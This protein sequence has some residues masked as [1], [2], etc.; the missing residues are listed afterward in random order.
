MLN[1]NFLIAITNIALIFFI[2][3]I[4][5]YATI[6]P[7]SFYSFSY[8][9]RFPVSVF[10]LII[11]SIILFFALIFIKR[12]NPDKNIFRLIL[13]SILSIII[14]TFS[15]FIALSFSGVVLE[16][17][18]ENNILDE[19]WS[20]FF[21]ILFISYLS[22]LAISILLF[23]LSIPK[24][25]F[26]DKTYQSAFRWFIVLVPL[27]VFTFVIFFIF[28]VSA[29]AQSQENAPTFDEN[30]CPLL[31]WQNELALIGTG[32]ILSLCL[33]LIFRFI[34]TKIANKI[35]Q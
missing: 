33:V 21:L 19:P 18:L 8:M 27:I 5:T 24:D 29:F 2:W 10:T 26:F 14:A 28:T 35:K 9:T 3:P 31:I 30:S 16:L 17:I 23:S 13:L 32:L 20:F 12:R 15:I 6:C 7:T 22:Y 1:K 25:S 34:L 11:S 4:S